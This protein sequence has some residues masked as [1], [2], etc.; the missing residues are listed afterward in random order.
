MLWEWANKKVDLLTTVS[1]ATAA[2]EARKRL[3]ALAHDQDT[4]SSTTKE[5]S[6]CGIRKFAEKN[7]QIF[8]DMKKHSSFESYKNSE[9]YK[10]WAAAGVNDD[11]D[12]DDN[13]N[14]VTEEAEVNVPECSTRK[15]LYSAVISVQD[16]EPS[17]SAC[18]SKRSKQTIG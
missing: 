18:A 2:V 6:R 7:P 15:R 13:N 12:I 4:V 1:T 16:C 8:A 10:K 11:N 9:S 17:I 3:F 5:A 14:F